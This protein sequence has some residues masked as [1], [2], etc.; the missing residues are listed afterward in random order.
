MSKNRTAHII[1]IVSVALFIVLGL[2]SG[3]TEP[4]TNTGNSSGGQASTQTQ[5]PPQPASPYFTGDGGKNIRLG[6][7]VPESQGLNADQ[8]YIPAMVQGVLVSNI[9]KYSGISVLDR[10]SLDRVI[11]ETLDPTYQDNLDIV[12][13]GHV[14]Q[15]GHM[16]TGK[17]IRT[18]SG[19]TLQLNITD[20]T[21]EAGTTAAYSGACTAAQLDD[22]TAIQTAA[23]E[24][25]TQMGVLL[26]EKAIA[27]LGTMSSP[28]SVTA[29]TV[30][31]QGIVAQKQG[32]EVAA[33]SYYYQAAAL[34][35]ALLEAATRSRALASNITSGSLTGNIGEDTRNDIQWRR[36]WVQRLTETEQYFDNF[37]KKSSPSWTLFYSTDIKQ[38]DINYQ[39]ET[40]TLSIETYLRGSRQWFEPVNQTVNRVVGAVYR[41]LEA[42]ERS[43][44]WGLNEWPQKGVTNLNPFIKRE[45]KYLIDAELVNS[46]NQVIGRTNIYKIVSWRGL[47]LDGTDSKIIISEDK[48]TNSFMNVKANDI[49]D[50]LTIRIASVNGIP[51]E[52]AVRNGVLNI[53]ALT[54][55]QWESYAR[56]T[57][58]YN[59]NDIYGSLTAKGMTGHLEIV[60]FWGEPVTAIGER[61]FINNKLTSVTIGDG[62]TYIG[63]F[64]FWDNPLTNITIGAN[65]TLN[66]Y[67]FGSGFPAF[68]NNNGKKAGTYTYSNRQ[69]TYKPSAPSLS[70]NTPTATTKFPLNTLNRA[71]LFVESDSDNQGGRSVASAKISRETIDKIA[72]DVINIEISLN[73]SD[74]IDYAWAELKITDSNLVERLKKANGIRFKVY[75]DGGNWDLAVSTVETQTDFANYHYP[76]QAARNRVSTI[77]IPYS[78]LRQPTWGRQVSFNKNSI[79][80]IS[81]HRSSDF[82]AFNSSTIK[83]FDIELT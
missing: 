64:A 10:V 40:V 24:L 14:A 69:W 21:P 46:R 49:T 15:V 56:M 55:T 68:Y 54:G 65:V 60:D 52:S 44:A 61:A 4:A 81:F 5:T 1:T 35:P 12:R 33:M 34:D 43:K 70:S 78:E 27:D 9:S 32:T 36:G 48:E 7:I 29:Q 51:A 30:L 41:G 80:S 66:E 42:T 28:Q 22:H 3:T 19:Y 11:A 76:F 50:S 82:G 8:A 59:D 39:N 45:V 13:L 2:A 6:I 72:H 17:I 38:G 16:M 71:N 75:G 79:I 23:R 74:K 83:V 18:S 37:F 53:T 63:Y 58:D 20:T 62:V 67:S 31:A 25:L 77:D 73:R 57:V 26:T 47:L